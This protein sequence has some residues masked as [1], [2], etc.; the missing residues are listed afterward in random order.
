MIIIKVCY[1]V[2]MLNVGEAMKVITE[3]R[4][5]EIVSMYCETQK[6]NPSLHLDGMIDMLD[7]LW[8][9]LE[10]IDTLTVSKLRPIVDVP[11]N[12]CDSS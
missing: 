3:K 6:S 2:S 5:K 10:E 11:K 1:Y 7:I 12:S 4:L 9:E 8:D